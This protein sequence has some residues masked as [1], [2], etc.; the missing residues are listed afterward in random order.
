MKEKMIERYPSSILPFGEMIRGMDG[1]LRY[2]RPVR[3]P[4][5]QLIY[6]KLTQ[7]AN[8]PFIYFCMES[9][10]VW[11]SVMGFSPD[12]NAHLDYLF[13]ESLYRRFSGLIS[14]TPLREA[15]EKGCHL[16]KMP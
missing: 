7:P 8:P 1:K 14:E 2:A 16:D 9:K 5:Y 4:M 10:V 3:V 13:A 15:Y 12:S 6:N 11:E